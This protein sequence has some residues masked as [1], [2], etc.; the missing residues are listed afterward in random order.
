LT[1]P[2]AWLPAIGT[3]WLAAIG[4]AWPLLGSTRNGQ[5]VLYLFQ[6]HFLYRE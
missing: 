3:A 2:K 1:V 4:T 6:K 5:A